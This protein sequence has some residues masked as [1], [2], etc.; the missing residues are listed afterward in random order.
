MYRVYIWTYV[1]SKPGS[2]SP[3]SPSIRLADFRPPGISLPESVAGHEQHQG[4]SSRSESTIQ[5]G[6]NRN[7]SSSAQGP[8]P[9]GGITEG[10]FHVGSQQGGV[11]LPMVI[12]RGGRGGQ[13]LSMDGLP[14]PPFSLPPPW[15]FSKLTFQI[16]SLLPNPCSQVFF[17]GNP[18]YDICHYNLMHAAEQGT[19]Y[20]LGGRGSVVC[21]S[22]E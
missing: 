20:S 15:V 17:W 5:P 2:A 19:G 22:A 13:L 14:S 1:I 12:T 3:I 4:G 7:W 8:M 10:R 6:T 18:Q 21:P 9:F 11:R 16:N